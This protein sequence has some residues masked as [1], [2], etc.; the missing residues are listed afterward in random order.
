MR[1][2]LDT[3]VGIW[4][5]LPTSELSDNA[6]HAI[7]TSVS[8]GYP[9]YVSAISIIETIYLV[10]YGQ[11]PLEARQRAGLNGPSSGLMIYPSIPLLRTRF[12]RFLDTPPRASRSHHPGHRRSP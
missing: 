9:V 3:H 1:V 12:T 5:L 8:A 11:L 4:F 7:R 10:E 2:L 6:I